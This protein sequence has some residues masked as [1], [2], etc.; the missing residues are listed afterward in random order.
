MAKNRNENTAPVSV[1]VVER[2]ET[3][4]QASG[5]LRLIELERSFVIFSLI[6]FPVAWLFLGRGYLE[7]F[8]LGIYTVVMV[9]LSLLMMGKFVLHFAGAA[10]NHTGKF[11]RLFAVY[12]FNGFLPL[13]MLKAF[14]HIINMILP[15]DKHQGIVCDL[16]RLFRQFYYDIFH[17]Q[18]A[19]NYFILGSLAVM[20]FFAVMSVRR[21]ESE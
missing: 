12:V 6:Y 8:L 4:N 1:E 7:Q 15:I 18:T 20:F 5:F 19:L 3:V 11:G 9:V 21:N 14:G 17:Y 10:D 2:V 13:V 16:V